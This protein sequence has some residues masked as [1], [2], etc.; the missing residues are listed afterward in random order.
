MRTQR[1]PRW[2]L[3]SLL[4]LLFVLP[5]FRGQAA[6]DGPL[7]TAAKDNDVAAVRASWPNARMSTSTRATDRQQFS[8][9][10]TIPTSRWQRR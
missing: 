8:G 2:L 7:V 6:G 3:A 10:P 1:I 5:S 9:P 4:F